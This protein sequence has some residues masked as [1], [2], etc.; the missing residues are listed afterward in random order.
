MAGKVHFDCFE[1]DLDSGQL[2]KRGA[3][4]KLRE[5]SFQVLASLLEHPGEV[6]TREELYRR[7][8]REEVFVDFDNN[9]NAAIARLREALNDCA[10]DPRFI[11][12]LP[13]HG[14]RFLGSVSCRMFPG[15]APTTRLLVL[16]L[17]NLSGDQAEEYFSDAMTDEIITALANLAPEHLAVIARTTAMHYKGSHKDIARI[18]RELNVDYV[19]E[20]S[21]RRNHD[22][23]SI[24]AQLI[25]ASDQTHVFAR[26]YNAEMHD[27]F[28]LHN[29][30][31]GD[32]ALHIP[33]I[34][35]A[36][37][38]GADL[39]EHIRKRPTEDL[40]AYNQYI[41][42][43]YEMWKMTPEAMRE[44]MRH[45]EAALMHDPRFALACNSLAELY[46]YLGLFGYAPSR[47]TDRIGRSYVLRSLDADS[48]LAD[49]HAL[50]SFYPA[51]RD[52]PNEIDYYDWAEIQK[53]VALARKLDPTSCLVRLRHAMVLAELGKPEEAVAE[54]ELMLESDPLSL[55]ARSW[56]TVMLYLSRRFDRAVEQARRNIEMEPEYFVPY[57]VAGQVYVSMK[58]FD[59]S[60]AAFQ[61]SIDHCPDLPML[62]GW[63]GLALGLG[64]H[65]AEARTVLKHVRSIARERYVP[66]TCFAWIHLGLG[67]IDEAFVWLERAIDAPDRMIEPI[68]TYPFLDP[69]RADPRFTALLRKMNLEIQDQPEMHAE[70]LKRTSVF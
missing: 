56:L 16:P 18:A 27:I 46:W 15:R 64:G 40:A 20:G 37:R 55:D 54:L 8:W 21:V 13:K 4:V 38:E 33:T 50:L 47:E 26:G 10:D 41:K 43:R 65:T 58:S 39:P 34:V 2:Y 45:F 68:K 9:L 31:T 57:D 14:Y 36:K 3:R 70:G 6:V 49:A 52:C 29:C 28:E 32:L 66:P 44:A 17:V 35:Q 22:Q 19:L 62:Q 24:N 11:E 61:K 48:S 63:L 23:V 59:E 5:K 69:L 53:E 67:D 51:K 7:L 12:T 42:G 60:V 1:V 30:I 25:Q